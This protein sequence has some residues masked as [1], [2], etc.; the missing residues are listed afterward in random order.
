MVEEL[1]VHQQQMHQHT[2]LVASHYWV[3]GFLGLCRKPIQH[4]HHLQC[5]GCGLDNSKELGTKLFCSCE[6]VLLCSLIVKGDVLVT[7][8]FQ[9]GSHAVQY[10]P[11]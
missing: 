2:A 5:R 11:A 6:H 3:S 7:T 4:V 10:M 9:L 8:L 1:E